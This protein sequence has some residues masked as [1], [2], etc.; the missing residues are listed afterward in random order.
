MQYNWIYIFKIYFL[1]NV[2]IGEINAIPG[3]DVIAMT[4]NGVTLARHL[5]KLKE[6][7]LNLINVSLDTLI[8]AKFEFVT[9]RKGWSHV[10][11]GIDTALELG[12]KPVKVWLLKMHCGM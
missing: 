4:T 10:M 8:P 12:Y 11:K 6:A 7:G 3:I 5:P 1:R 9:R 2:F